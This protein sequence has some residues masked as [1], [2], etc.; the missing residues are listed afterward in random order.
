MSALVLVSSFVRRDVML[1]GIVFFVLVGWRW[2]EISDVLSDDVNF[3]VV[4]SLA[5]LQFA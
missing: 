5:F 3:A 1:S 2:N 4:E